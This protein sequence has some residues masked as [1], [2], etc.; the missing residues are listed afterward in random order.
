MRDLK[1]IYYTEV[2]NNTKT[3]GVFF[4]IFSAILYYILKTKLKFYD[5]V[6]W[7]GGEISKNICYFLKDYEVLWVIPDNKDTIITSIKSCDSKLISSFNFTDVKDYYYPRLTESE[8]YYLMELYGLSEDQ[9]LRAQENFISESGNRFETCYYYNLDK[10]SI[11][12]DT[13][14][15]HSISGLIKNKLYFT[16]STFVYC[17]KLIYADT[18]NMVDYIELLK[19]TKCLPDESLELNITVGYCSKTVKTDCIKFGLVNDVHTMLRDNNIYYQRP[20]LFAKGPLNNLKC[21]YNNECINEIVKSVK[22]LELEKGK[23][24]LD[25]R[26][27][28]SIPCNTVI[29]LTPLNLKGVYYIRDIF[30][31]CNCIQHI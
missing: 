5:Y 30:I 31:L 8:I 13:V 26:C 9:I 20:E 11:N 25:S 24:I 29:P 7:G 4:I 18:G 19:K 2:K 6:V 17:N 21:V 14:K 16:D 12:C 22:N 1:F 3:I 27:S 15:K 10:K 23:Y 28:C